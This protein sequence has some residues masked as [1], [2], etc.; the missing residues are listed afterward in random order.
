MSLPKGH[1]A[2]KPGEINAHGRHADLIAKTSYGS[3]QTRVVCADDVKKI[4]S[5]YF[6]FDPETKLCIG[7]VSK[8]FDDVFRL[9]DQHNF[10]HHSVHSRPCSI[11]IHHPD[12]W[13][14]RDDYRMSNGMP[15]PRGTAMGG[16]NRRD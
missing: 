16:Y 1:I 14:N 3:H 5:Q 6:A 11:N 9:E 15:D 8:G 7:E 2:T 4:G 13:Y 10:S 12:Y